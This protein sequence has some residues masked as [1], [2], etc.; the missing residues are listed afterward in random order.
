MY[1]IYLFGLVTNLCGF[2]GK[3]ISPDHTLTRESEK[4]SM[5]KLK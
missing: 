2:L 3:D 4:I 5:E 1:K